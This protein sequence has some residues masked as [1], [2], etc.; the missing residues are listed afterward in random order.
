MESITLSEK[1]T[2]GTNRKIKQNAKCIYE[3]LSYFLQEN[4]S[5]DNSISEDSEIYK[6]I[7]GNEFFACR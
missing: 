6:H 5:S 1:K 3:P 2:P 4:E 7:I